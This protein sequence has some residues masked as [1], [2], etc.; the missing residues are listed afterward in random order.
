[1]KKCTVQILDTADLL[2]VRNILYIYDIG[3]ANVPSCC[4]QIP[5]EI[6]YIVLW[7][8]V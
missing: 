7:L 1:M 3:N 6:G 4:G 8:R 2:Y 5:D